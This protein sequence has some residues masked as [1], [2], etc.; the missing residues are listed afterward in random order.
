[1]EENGS[2]Y[3]LLGK[4]LEYPRGDLREKAHQCAGLVAAL[5][6]EAQGLMEQFLASI[7]DRSP[8]S[9]EETYTATFDLNPACCPY[10]GYQLVGEDPKR[11]ALMLKLQEDYRAAGFA[12]G[13]ELPDHLAVMLRFLGHQRDGAVERDLVEN[14]LLPALQKMAPTLEETHP[15]GKLLR[16]VAAVLAPVDVVVGAPAAP[17]GGEAAP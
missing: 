2:L 16:A 13:N 1:M 3:R 6:P 8:G 11:A 17:L 12:T 15:Y 4:L 10:V 9:L 5:R 14:A 7:E